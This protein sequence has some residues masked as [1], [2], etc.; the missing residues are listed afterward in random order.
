[1]CS[2]KLQEGNKAGGGVGGKAEWGSGQRAAHHWECVS[3]GREEL[4]SLCLSYALV[5]PQRPQLP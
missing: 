3:V 5:V 1:M 2:M 4:P